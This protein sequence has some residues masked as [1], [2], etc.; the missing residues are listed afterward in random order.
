[1]PVPK[2]YYWMVHNDKYFRYAP[3]LEISNEN[4]LGG[5]LLKLVVYVYETSCTD[6]DPIIKKYV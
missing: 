1:M 6:I 4:K 2:P 3:K 5:M